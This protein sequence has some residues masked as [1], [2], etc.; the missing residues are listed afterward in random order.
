MASRPYKRKKNSP[1]YCLHQNPSA[2]IVSVLTRLQEYSPRQ[3]KMQQKKEI[4]IYSK[5]RKQN[6]DGKKDYPDVIPQ[7]LQKNKDVLM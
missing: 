7:T 4:Q 2:Q 6:G 1:C 5:N 3:V